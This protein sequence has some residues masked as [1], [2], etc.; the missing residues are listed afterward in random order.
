M[1][2]VDPITT[3]IIRN[4]F[5][6]I[7]DDMNAALI[8][9]AFTP[10]IYEGK[11]CSVAL[12]DAQANVLGQSPGLPLF[13]GNLEV[14]VQLIADRHGW[15]YFCDGDVFYMNDSY[16]TGTHLNDSTVI[17]PIFRRGE[18]IGFAASRAHWL[19]VGAKD[20]G[21]PVDSVEIYQ[22]GM[23]WGPTKLYDN[24]RPRE[25]VIDVLRLNSRFGDGL[26][27]DLNA[28]IAAGRTGE[29]RLRAL[30][31]RFGKDVV[32]AARDAIFEQ[33]GTRERRAVRGIRNGR[34]Q[35][36]GWLDNDG[37]DSG[38]VPVKVTAIVN[39][40]SITIDLEGSGT[41]TR[42]PVN[43]GFTQTIAAARVAFKLLVCS[44]DPVNGGSFRTLDVR[45]PEH[46]IFN[47]RE[48]APCAW[49]FSSLGLLI[50]L[51]VKALAP[52][53]P[54]EAAGA[55]YGDSMVVTIAGDDP[56][57]GGQRYLMV[58]PTTGGWGAFADGDGADS[59][60]NNV[61]GNF[62]DLPVEIFEN[63]YPVLIESYGIRTDSGGAGRFR[64]GNGTCRRYRLRA[65][66]SLSLWFERSVTSAWG[67]FGGN[68]GSAPEVVIEEPGREPVHCLKVN[69]MP[70][71]AGTIITSRTGGG[72]GFGAAAERDPQAVRQDLVD[73]LVSQG[74][75]THAYGV[76]LKQS[77]D[78]P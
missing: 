9:S 21:A 68:S 61:N 32:T 33:T 77:P 19:D 17:M 53:M 50:D 59:L 65:S 15:E 8:R 42:G 45:A 2:T 72:G 43:C 37:L 18:R 26:I 67:L 29:Q 24:G 30:F 28:Q 25:D 16:M 49:Y 52:V 71:A 48:P 14:C 44:D 69:S 58:E 10:I 46:T 6:A 76:N 39:D 11:D 3:E 54:N 74:R 66:A 38:P 63:K 55:H 51:V 5:N 70:L 31:E 36:E 23:R 60:I 41:Q 56:R 7:A 12:L 1:K 20:P 40:E 78:I 75:A 27:G 13:L 73:G 22:E 35:S 4:A 34:Y 47:A 57:R 62:K 64:G